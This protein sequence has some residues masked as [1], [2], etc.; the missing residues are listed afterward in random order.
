MA[1]ARN[2]HER[3]RPAAARRRNFEQQAKPKRRDPLSL[4]PFA[5]LLF[6]IAALTSISNNHDANDAARA[7]DTA[8]VGVVLRQGRRGAQEDRAGAFAASRENDADPILAAAG[9]YDG[10]SGALV[11]SLLARG[12]A[13]GARWGWRGPGGLLS[14]LLPAL[15]QA[16]SSPA[17][18]ERCA[19]IFERTFAAFNS[20]LIARWLAPSGRVDGATALV[21]VVGAAAEEEEG[22]EENDDTGGG[23]GERDPPTPSPQP[24]PRLSLTIANVGNSRATLCVRQAVEVDD[25]EDDDD[26]F[27]PLPAQA[28]WRAAPLTIDHLP[29]RP[30][31]R[32]R[33]AAVAASSP[34]FTSSLRAAASRTEATGR[35]AGELEVSRSFG[36]AALY[37]RL[38]L[39]AAPEVSR[40]VVR[41]GGGE[42]GGRDSA[43][44][45][46]ELL[47]LA[48]DGASEVLSPGEVCLE[49]WAAAAAGRASSAG[50]SSPDNKK[51]KK[52][53]AVP[54]PTPARP[55]AVALLPPST[56]NEAELASAAAAA[57]SPR[58]LSRLQVAVARLP[59]R[60]ALRLAGLGPEWRPRAPPGC[61]DCPF[62]SASASAPSSLDGPPP[63]Y[64]TTRARAAAARVAAEAVN[65]GSGDNVGV[66]VLDV[67][68]LLKQ[69][70][71][72]SRPQP[73]R[74]RLRAIASSSSLSP[75]PAPLGG[76]SIPPA[77]NASSN[78]EPRG[79]A[80]WPPL[81][82]DARL[83]L[84]AQA[85]EAR[86][87][88]LEA[89]DRLLVVEGAPDE[90]G[91][92]AVVPARERREMRLRE[93]AAPF[94]SSSSEMEEDER[95]SA[96]GVCE[97]VVA[98]PPLPPLALGAGTAS[99]AVV[100]V[101]GEGGGKRGDATMLASL[102]CE[103]GGDYG[104]GAD[105]WGAFWG[106]RD[107]E[108][109]DDADEEAARENALLFG[110]GRDDQGASSS[111]R[112]R[113]YVLERV[114]PSSSGF[115]SSSA[116]G[117]ASPPHAHV[118]PLP[119]SSSSPRDNASSSSSG[120]G[121]DNGALVV[122]SHW[123]PP[124]SGVAGDAG[125]LPSTANGLLGP[126]S[127]PSL[128]A[129]A[130]SSLALPPARGSGGS[131]GALP[132]SSL[133]GD[134]LAALE[135]AP[136]PESG[137][138]GGLEARGYRIP[139]TPNAGGKGGGGGGGRAGA[140][141]AP[142]ATLVGRG[143]FG[144]VWRARRRRRGGE[145]QEDG[146]DDDNGSF[147][148]KRVAGAAGSAA[149][150]SA[151]RE[152]FFGRRL[153]E[154]AAAAASEREDREGARSCRLFAAG[155]SAPNPQWSCT[156]P[157]AAARA[158]S[159][160]HVGRFVEAFRTAP[161]AAAAEAASSAA[162]AA[163]A[164][165][166][167]PAAPDAWLVF[168]DEGR[169]LHDLM[170]SAIGGRGGG[171]GENENVPRILGPSEWWFSRRRSPAA[172]RRF[173]REVMSQLLRAL[174]ASHAQNVTHRDV[175]P[176]NLLVREG[177]K[178]ERPPL[179]G[180]AAAQSP[181]HVRLIDFGSAA[182]SFSLD[183]P[184]AEDARLLRRLYG[185][186]GPGA[187]ELTLDYA[188]PELLFGSAAAE[189]DEGEEEDGGREGGDEAATVTASSALVAQR[190]A[191]VDVY[192][193]GVVMLELVL[194]TPRVFALSAAAAEALD[195]R[196]LRGG[197]GGAAGA[198]AAGA[199][200]EAAARR[201]LAFHL[202]GLMDACLYPPPPPALNAKKQQQQ[203][204][205]ETPECAPAA[206]AA[207]LRRRDPL[208][209]GLDL[210]GLDL[211]RSLLAWRPSD[212]PSAAEALRHAFFLGEDEEE[213]EEEEA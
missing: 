66:V 24:H 133:V 106:G 117:A 154:E 43:V 74:R 202:R 79:L 14:S 45:G 71:G 210:A 137:N 127:I 199:T 85:R 26:P 145:D 165:P 113:L 142:A 48:T 159:I 205:V 164:T 90:R 135:A 101:G 27:S 41:G 70:A 46:A 148:L 55:P 105:N 20:G 179:S 195:R 169:S 186:R 116:G 120:D 62:L 44:A 107:D 125:A 35:L 208:G 161:L 143:A 39:S 9:L 100:A 40:L 140:D 16:P 58:L 18:L 33:L 177:Q 72:G 67:A 136:P 139:R 200:A 51:N 13:L 138:A 157:A 87:F 128:P 10:H 8:A 108:E 170:Y 144:E 194:G 95:D 118:L 56:P 149:R 173:V 99:G 22:G 4:L 75:G 109:A 153:A 209:H 77:K 198:G 206:L 29:T 207:A 57:A 102:I 166:S 185:R 171:D 98:V 30:D 192:A 132:P 110:A 21:A 31:E 52:G 59:S 184:A 17:T 1:A 34:S 211:A 146:D 119:S 103:S 196:L 212:R 81:P 122:T 191:A 93:S 176:E 156:D 91:A 204:Q 86:R 147:V 172:S 203:Q 168:R 97:A 187:G 60:L 130:S 82:T 96:G 11:A 182:P 193:A 47:V 50:S 23:E 160:D 76:S 123:W 65:R 69:E 92:L 151:L 121:G 80:F 61:T 68:W 7:L 150:R 141:A 54:A 189:E 178:E 12:S 49:A 73:P 89:A 64:P 174:A 3:R 162:A 6:G 83:L 88:A 126:A 124:H 94:C 180:A 131:A 197:G 158:G 84:D 15:R 63:P 37:R 111:S 129:S 134:L 163:A 155:K 112:R 78:S 32:R 19:P 152:A 25:G 201:R 53:W 28:P 36:D 213:E 188:P 104:A 167:P 114:V 181:L 2:D 38:G 175:K 190:R 183:R 42:Q 115:A 5:L